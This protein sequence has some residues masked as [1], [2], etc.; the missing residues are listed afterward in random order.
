MPVERI[1]VVSDVHGNL[2]AYE[3]VLADIASR[4][5]HRVINLGDVVGKGPRGSACTAL[6]RERC[7]STVR[8]NWEAFLAGDG[9][10]SGDG[11][12][13]WRA[14]LTAQDRAWLHALPG[15]LDLRLSGRR[16]RLV[17]ASPIDEFT[18][19]H[20]EPDD[21]TFA[22]MFEPTPFTGDAGRADVV[23]YGDIHDA[24][25]SAQPGATLVNVGSVG[26]PLDEPTPSY[27]ILEGDPDGDVQV[28][29]GIQFVRVS[30]DA[31]A[32]IEAAA[33]SGM[34][35]REIQAYAIEL[36][37]GVYRGLHAQLGLR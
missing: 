13:W 35:A 19:V 37:T 21:E 22:M 29:F 15:S 31:E 5:I 14:E 27:V 2:T 28:P 34:P 3:A 11:L 16:V 9:E 23:A 36:R 17:H 25:V 20:R 32:E 6:T 4:G 33:A 1:A 30:Y 10:L 12:R 7:E 24:F 26:N 18:R 8:G